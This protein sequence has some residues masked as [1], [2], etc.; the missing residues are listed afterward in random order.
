V[1]AMTVAAARTRLDMKNMSGILP[2]SFDRDVR[3]A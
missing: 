1:G 3:P 2:L